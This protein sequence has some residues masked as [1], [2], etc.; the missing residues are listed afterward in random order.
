MLKRDDPT[1]VAMQSKHIR[2]TMDTYRRSLM[3][4][5][6][7]LPSDEVLDL[8]AAALNARNDY[9]EEAMQKFI[10]EMNDIAWEMGRV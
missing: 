1:A 2:E 3:M 5:I 4:A 10:R 8:V 6:R 9:S 7:A